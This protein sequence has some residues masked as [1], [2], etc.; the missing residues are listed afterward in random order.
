MAQFIARSERFELVRSTNDVVRSWLQ[1][2]EPEVCL[3]VADEQSAGRGRDGR[4]WSA[5]AGAALLLSVGFRPSWLPV[6]Q[7]WRL[8]ASVSLA[9]A[10]AG[11]SNA[12]LPAGS[13]R[14]KWPND[15]VV[16]AGAGLRKLA[17]VLGE[18]TGIGTD[19]P[20]VV[21][22]IGVNGDWPADAFP[23]DLAGTMTSLRALADGRPIDHAV[24]LDA[25]VERLEGRIL[26]LRDGRFDVDEWADRQVTTGRDVVLIAPDGDATTVRALGVDP[27]TGVLVVADP[28][29][30]GGQR[31]VV[32][33]EIR[34]VRLPAISETT[35]TSPAAAQARV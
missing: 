3:A 24:L 4:T 23:A 5:P 28:T 20:R 19:D 11:E 34:H 8:A 7:L 2:G 16:E 31:T 30:D 35:A 25:F 14:L 26:A 32:V 12:G 9:M 17:G 15:L 10:E 29:V 6:A 22:G 27:S 18:S 33:G 13:I 21:I 1:D